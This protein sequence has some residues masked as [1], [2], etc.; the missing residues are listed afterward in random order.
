MHDRPKALRA[1][2]KAV[3]A[4]EDLD[5]PD[6]LDTVLDA[7]ASTLK[8]FCE[9]LPESLKSQAAPL[10]ALLAYLASQDGGLT[11][12]AKAASRLLETA[13]VE[14]YDGSVVEVRLD[15]I[16]ERSRRELL[17]GLESLYES[18]EAEAE[19]G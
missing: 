11:A 14:R 2:R 6:Q 7:V 9:N 5:E 8:P 1:L 18:I 16:N 12:A 3:S 15:K 4:L 17:S 13:S 19:D 10:D